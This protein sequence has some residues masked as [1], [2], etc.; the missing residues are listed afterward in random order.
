MAEALARDMIGDNEGVTFL[1]AGTYA[2]DGNPATSTGR[3]AAA[4]LGVE[5]E[6]HRARSLTPEMVRA[7]DIVF[8][9]ERGQRDHVRSVDPGVNVLL[10][11]P[12]GTEVRD[13]YGEDLGSYLASYAII[14]DALTQRLAELT[15]A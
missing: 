11:Q 4:M 8:V 13:P 10:L 12:D 9:M 5:I 7:A 1:S 3:A 15:E 14:R 2:I 6:S